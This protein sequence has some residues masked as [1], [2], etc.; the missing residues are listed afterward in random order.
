MS[1]SVKALSLI[2][3]LATTPPT[4]AQQS[5][6]TVQ[7]TVESIVASNGFTTTR[8]LVDYFSFLPELRKDL[9]KLRG[10]DRWLD[11]GAGDLV[12]LKQ[13]LAPNVREAMKYNPNYVRFRAMYADQ[14]KTELEFAKDAIDEIG[15][16]SVGQ[17]ADVVAVS[18]KVER[19]YPGG[20]EKL[21][22]L[23]GRFFENIP[24]GEIGKVNLI[25]DLYGVMSYGGKL[26]VDLSKYFELLAPGGRIHFY[27]RT[28]RTTIQT[29]Q[30]Q[31]LNLI[32]W[33]RTIPGIEVTRL[34][35]PRT[36]AKS[37]SY[38]LERKIAGAPVRIPR[39]E[40]ISSQ[41]GRPPTR[42]FKELSR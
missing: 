15:A 24:N 30:G 28:D 25:T 1:A 42:H 10:G 14:I 37:G 22:V 6:A 3:A 13:Y 12:A 8:E 36:S 9:A 5:C 16:L 39:L 38:V 21:K 35:G 19:E 27:A 33:L 40:L 26:D 4:Q 11:A 31:K 17:R 23:E 18:F 20:K 34:Q 41:G 29:L 32:D 2:L 7:G